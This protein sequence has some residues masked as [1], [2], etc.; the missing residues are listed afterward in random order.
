M[1]DEFDKFAPGP[2]LSTMK[3]QRIIRPG[4]GLGGGEWGFKEYAQQQQT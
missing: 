1:T 3:G 4:L 2:E